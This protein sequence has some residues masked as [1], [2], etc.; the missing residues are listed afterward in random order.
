MI[1]AFLWGGLAAS[2]LLVGALLA[3][4]TTP[5]RKVIAVVMAL[6]AGLLIGS[7]AFELIDEALATTE[8][9]QVGRVTLVAIGFAI[10]L[11]LSAI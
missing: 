3:Y 1:E 11:M 7:V 5:S 6:G 9:A 8:V 10:S 2:A 4:I